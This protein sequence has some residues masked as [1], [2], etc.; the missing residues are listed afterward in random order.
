MTEATYTLILQDEA[1]IKMVPINSGG[2]RNESELA[3]RIFYI[4]LTF[5]QCDYLYI[6]TRKISSVKSKVKVKSL[7]HVRLFR[8][9]GL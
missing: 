3:D 4:M 2:D 7:S 8:P 6:K 5:E 1:E 9:H